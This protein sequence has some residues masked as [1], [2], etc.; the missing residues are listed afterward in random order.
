M[1]HWTSSGV[2][3]TPTT[4]QIRVT[5]HTDSTLSVGH[6]QPTRRL[7]LE[8]FRQNLQY[9]RHG[10]DTPRSISC[11]SITI[12]GLPIDSLAAD[13]FKTLADFPFNYA[14]LHLST[15]TST[16][17]CWSVLEQ[18]EGV[19]DRFVLSFGPNIPDLDIPKWVLPKLYCIVSLSGTPSTFEPWIE[20][21]IQQKTAYSTHVVFSYPVPLGPNHPLPPQS[22]S[23][24]FSRLMPLLKQRT[25]PTTLKG[26]PV[27]LMPTLIHKNVTVSSKTSNRWYVDAEHQCSEALLFFPDI[28]HYH[29]D[30]QCR[31]CIHDGHCDGFFL[32]YLT[33]NIHLSAILDDTLQS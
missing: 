19:F 16:P 1:I 12:S 22:I 6:A 17:I 24:I 10:L 30:D 8:E 9:F 2:V 3:S 14:T 28:L 18:Y 33:N 23:S 32:E 5:S 7:S 15:A 26:L 21:W 11:T 20:H 13:Y 4:V 31:F 27:C 29:K 25:R